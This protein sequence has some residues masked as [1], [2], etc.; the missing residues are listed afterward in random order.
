MAQVTCNDGTT[1]VD[2]GV[3]APC[4]GNG[5]VKQ[6]TQGGGGGGIPEDHI[7]DNNP[8]KDCA[9]GFYG[10]FRWHCW[11]K[12][13]QIAFGIGAAALLG[14]GIL[15][16]KS[17]LNIAGL[18][19]LGGISGLIILS[20]KPRLSTDASQTTNEQQNNEQP[21]VPCSFTDGDIVEATGWLNSDKADYNFSIISDTGCMA[22]T[23][24]SNLDLL[25]IE[26]AM[27][28]DMVQYR[29]KATLK[30][31]TMVTDAFK[32]NENVPIIYT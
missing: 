7:N 16:K 31:A 14:Y 19:L 4:N 5:G 6:N 22:H 18:T 21:Y 29:G 2:N 26:K 8:R 32:R 10:D 17:P 20:M 25:D 15:K 12:D 27:T 9:G 30:S 3:V 24:L 23:L 13:A 11:R 28:S 1:D